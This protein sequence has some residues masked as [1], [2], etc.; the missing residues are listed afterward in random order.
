V[1][2]P[3][4]FRHLAE[5]D[6]GRL[7]IAFDRQLRAAELDLRDRPAD[8]RKRKITLTIELTPL[9]HKGDFDGA[10][11]EYFVTAKTPHEQGNTI[12]ATPKRIENKWVLVMPTIGNDA[13]QNSI[14]FG[15]DE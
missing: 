6:N 10:E 12:R 11:I 14:D 8:N 1:N 9:E 3:L 2:V 15:S 4:S 13:N 5:L 7:A